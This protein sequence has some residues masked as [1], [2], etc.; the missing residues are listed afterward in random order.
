MD[1]N[2]YNTISAIL[3]EAEEAKIELSA[4]QH[5]RLKK[6][7]VSWAARQ[8]MGPDTDFDA[9]VDA[10]QL[11]ISLSRRRWLMTLD[12]ARTER[13]AQKAIN[14]VPSFVSP[15]LVQAA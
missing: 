7:V 1:R 3:E 10:V 11:G 8:G 2:E 15:F 13:E 6:V 14:K 9:L 4:D 12:E 5:R